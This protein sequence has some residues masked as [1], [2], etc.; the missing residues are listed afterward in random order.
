LFLLFEYSNRRGG[1][2]KTAAKTRPVN[3]WMIEG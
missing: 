1:G 3:S 2:K